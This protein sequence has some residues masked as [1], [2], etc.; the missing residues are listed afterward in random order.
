MHSRWLMI[1]CSMAVLAGV[2]NAQPIVDGTRDAAYGPALALQTVQTGFGDAS[3]ADGLGSGGELDALYAT[4]DD[5]RLYVMLTGNIENS[6]NKLSVFFDTQAGGENTLS[7]A[8]AYDFE[9]ISQNFGGLT[10]D[11]GFAADYHLYARWG[12]FSGNVF[13]VDIVDRQGGVNSTVTGNGASSSSGAGTAIQSGTVLPTDLGLTAGPGGTGEVRTLDGFLTE[14]LAFGFNNTNTA[15]VTSGTGAANQAAAAAV[16]TGFEFSIALADLGPLQAGDEIKLHTVYG[17]S[18]HNFHSN[19]TLPGLPAGTGNL[20][21]NGNGTFTGDLAGV[22][23][24]DFAGDQFLTITVPGLVGDYND[25]NRVDIAD[26]TVWRDG[27]GD[28]FTI[29]HYT[30]WANNFGAIGPANAQ[31]VPTPEPAASA[32]ACLL[33]LIFAGVRSR[34]AR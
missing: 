22:D 6:F 2:A 15:G 34:Y 20:G 10:F 26:Y 14:P 4:I 13:A 17:N 32:I 30:A 27:L 8:P 16:T 3:Q 19:Q 29:A 1:F 31:A 11:D 28:Q 9:N 33:V 18:N 25:D 21:G 23:F 24:G 12:S 7:A 5:D